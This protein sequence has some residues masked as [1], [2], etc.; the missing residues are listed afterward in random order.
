ML[1][2][3]YT[4][5]I[6]TCMFILYIKCQSVKNQLFCVKKLHSNCTV[7]V[8]GEFTGGKGVTINCET[9]GVVVE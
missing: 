8:T 1:N 4:N 7:S 9:A 6:Y 5:G 2:R 3:I